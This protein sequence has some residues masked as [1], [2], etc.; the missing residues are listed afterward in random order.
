MRTRS[1]CRA[2]PPTGRGLNLEDLRHRAPDGELAVRHQ[3]GLPDADP[4]FGHHPP[5]LLGHLRDI[6]RLHVL[7]AQLLRST[8]NGPLRR[9]TG[10]A[11]D[12]LIRRASLIACLIAETMFFPRRS[13]PRSCITWARTSSS[14]RSS[15]SDSIHLTRDTS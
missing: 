6:F 8:E 2:G 12:G 1:L 7:D 13:N 11:Q 10:L 9:L 4:E 5:D 15:V 14:V 3:E